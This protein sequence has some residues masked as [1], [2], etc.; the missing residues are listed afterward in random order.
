[1]DHLVIV[2]IV[3]VVL[4]IAAVRA[5]GRQSPRRGRGSRSGGDGGGSGCGGGFSCGGSSCG[6]GGGGD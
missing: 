6:G 2:G 3:G 5:A 1:M 4:F